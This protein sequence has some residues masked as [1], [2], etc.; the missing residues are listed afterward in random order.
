M[1]LYQYPDLEAHK[2]EHAE[3]VA[4]VAQFREG[5]AAGRIGLT[6]E[7]MRYLSSWLTNHIM[8]TDRAFGPF[9]NDR[10]LCGY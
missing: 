2:A 7:V 9:F 6:I 10:G 1:S 3:F 8:G 5:F 4:S